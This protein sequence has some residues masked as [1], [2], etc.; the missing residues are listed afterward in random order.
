MLAPGPY[1]RR[2]E[3]R[4]RVHIY[5]LLVAIERC[6]QRE[7]FLWQLH[8]KSPIIMREWEKLT[9]HVGATAQEV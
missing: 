5:I 2:C 3:R 4:G 8:Y 1:G 7:E 6:R 9:R